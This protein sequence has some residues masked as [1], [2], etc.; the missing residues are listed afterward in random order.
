MKSDSK[1]LVAGSNGMVGSAI[2]R[3]LENKGYT[4]VL[5]GTR[6]LVD[7]TDKEET[8]TFFKLSKPEYVFLTA[9]KCGGILDNA[10][11][12][13]D[14]LLNNLNIQNNIIS[15]SHEY[16]VKKLMFFASSCVYPKNSSIPIKEENLLMGSLE[17]SHEFYSIAKISG[18]KLCEAY[19]KQYGCN[20]FS[21]NPCNIY[22]IENK[23]DSPNAHVMSSLIY[24]IWTAKKNNIDF[25]ECFG[26]GSPKRE[27]LYSDD[28]ADAA[29]FL[30][31]TDVESF[32]NIGTGI[33]TSIKDLA[34]LI[35][36]IVGY[37]GKIIWD[38]TKPN[39]APIR[40]LD[41]TKLNSLGWNAKTSI[42]EG[43]IKIINHLD[44][45]Y[46]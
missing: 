20:F 22:G 2:V 27:F 29:I 8:N 46:V 45:N 18:I 5:K 31:N 33:E 9:A 23:I 16:G 24:K 42:K 14:Y 30:M 10:N 4:N 38:T 7:F 34:N 17:K 1:I 35:C 12:P 13:V 36:K 41:V 39:G 25:V 6:H 19:K 3:S 11:Y 43:I 37:R 15:L 28:L 32:I 44:Q 40:V 21:V 26:D